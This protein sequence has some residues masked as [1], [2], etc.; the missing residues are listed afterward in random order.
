MVSIGKSRGVSLG[1]NVRFPRATA[2]HIAIYDCESWAMTRG[3]KK[4]VD[5]FELWCYRILLG[6]HGWRGKRTNGV[7][8]DWLCFDAE[9]EYGRRGR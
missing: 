6:C 7:E 8:L 4:R 9:K 1:L 5:A 2:S 3:E